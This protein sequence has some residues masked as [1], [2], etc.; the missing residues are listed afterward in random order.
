MDKQLQAD[1][2]ILLAAEIDSSDRKRVAAN[3]NP[4]MTVIACVEIGN[5]N[6]SEAR[7]FSSQLAEITPA[8]KSIRRDVQDVVKHM[9]YLP[10]LGSKEAAD[11]KVDEI[12]RLGITEFFV[13]QD[14]TPLRYGISLGIFKSEEA[15]QTHVANLLHRGVSGARVVSRNVS[16]HKVAFQLQDLNNDA[17]AAVDKLKV[18]FPNQEMHR[19]G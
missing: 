17:Q 6:A 5:F 8:I 4:A 16:G 11:K 18:S 9:V 7:N 12:Q 1:K 3:I 13:I 15:A 19:C 10:S 2:V 14:T